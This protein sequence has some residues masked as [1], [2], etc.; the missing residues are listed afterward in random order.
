MDSNYRD[1]AT[2]MVAMADQIAA[3]SFEIDGTGIVTLSNV[4]D[5]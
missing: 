3:A 5:T 4:T 2:T 1:S